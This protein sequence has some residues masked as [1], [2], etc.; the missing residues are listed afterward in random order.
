MAEN[1]S[2]FN[3]NEVI[4]R[5]VI[6]LPEI[7]DGFFHA[8]THYDSV[9][10]LYYRIDPEN[11]NARTKRHIHIWKKKDKYNGVSWNFD[12]SRHDKGSFADSFKHLNAAKNLAE[13]ILNPNPSMPFEMILSTYR[14]Q[15]LY[16]WIYEIVLE[17]LLSPSE[18]ECIYFE[19]PRG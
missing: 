2:E 7:P 6:I 8:L 5:A 13:R 10:R 12:G 15:S 9:T 16:M 19:L 18:D 14:H 4:K 17:I 1:E 3:E 11:E